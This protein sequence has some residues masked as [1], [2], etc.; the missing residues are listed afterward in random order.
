[1]QRGRPQS[2]RFI[3]LSSLFRRTMKAEPLKES[4]FASAPWVANRVSHPPTGLIALTYCTHQRLISR[5][6]SHLSH[7]RNC[8]SGICSCHHS[9]KYSCDCSI[10]H[11]KALLDHL[12]F[13]LSA[14]KVSEMGRP[15]MSVTKATSRSPARASSMPYS[16]ALSLH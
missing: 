15:K 7:G 2:W 4:S 3:F 14:Q 11:L 12:L 5:L 10:H 1:M 16:P 9:Y 8:H 13:T 6:R